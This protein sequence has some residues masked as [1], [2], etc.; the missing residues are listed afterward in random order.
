MMMMMVVVA[1]MVTMTMMTVMIPV[2]RPFTMAGLAWVTVGSRT[3]QW[4]ILQTSYYC[5]ILFDLQIH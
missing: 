2:A 5:Q 1:V 3:D 4:Q